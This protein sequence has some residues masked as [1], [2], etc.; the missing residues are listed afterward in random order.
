MLALYYYCQIYIVADDAEAR[1][2]MRAVRAPTLQPKT[3]VLRL[4]R[5][6][7][8]SESRSTTSAATKSA[9]V[10]TENIPETA[11]G[12]VLRP[13]LAVRVMVNAVA[14]GMGVVELL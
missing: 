8:T 6:G 14:M 12:P 2:R 10:V 7:L 3:R 13:V 5:A 4:D 9:M 11:E 1:W